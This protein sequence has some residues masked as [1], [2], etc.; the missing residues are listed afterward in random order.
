MFTYNKSLIPFAKGLRKNMTR[1]ERKLWY[2]YLRNA[3]VRF[4]R[5]KTILG[6]IVDFYAA[7][8]KL[9]VEID[10]GQHFTE[11]AMSYDAGRTEQLQEMDVEI[12]RFTN[13]EVDENFDQVC[14]AIEYAVKQRLA[15]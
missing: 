12:I 6:Y 14:R 1:Q 10:G 5:Q 15:K 8:V 9:G 7:S 11:E 4:Q 13:I 2:D 3:G